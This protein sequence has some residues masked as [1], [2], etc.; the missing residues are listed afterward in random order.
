[1]D[2]PTDP[3]LPTIQRTIPVVLQSP[4]HAAAHRISVY[5]LGCH[6]H[7]QSCDLS[8]AHI[9]RLALTTLAHGEHVEYSWSQSPAKPP[10][11]RVP[12]IKNESAVDVQKKSRT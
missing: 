8:L 9:T 12:Q 2:D 6:P 11:A 7:S 5:P 10:I 1:M 3:P 4:W